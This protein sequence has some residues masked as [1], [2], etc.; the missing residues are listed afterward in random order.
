VGDVY[1]QT[2]I[3]E[4]ETITQSDES[5]CNDVVSNELLKILAR[6]LQLQHQDNR[7]LCPV[8]SLEQIVGLEIR[9][10]FTVGETLKHGSGVEVPQS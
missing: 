7:L 4:V 1:R 6:L 2:D 8:T 10:V 9:L 3:S 5:E